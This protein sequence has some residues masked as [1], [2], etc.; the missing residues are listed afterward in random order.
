[1][2]MRRSAAPDSGG[3]RHVPDGVGRR[4]RRDATFAVE[5]IRTLAVRDDQFE[6]RP[7]PAEPFANSLGAFSGRPELI[8]I[9]FDAEV[10][11]YVASR[12]WHRSQDIRTCDDGSIVM[13]LTVC[14]DRPLRTWILGFGGAAPV[15]APASLA[16]DIYEEFD[17]GRDRYTPR[18]PFDSLPLAQDRPF[19]SLPPMRLTP[20][21]MRF[22]EPGLPFAA[23][24][25]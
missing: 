21:K 2:R 15:L 16:R 23:R 6:L 14:S 7:L 12:E 17:A 11:A 5:R 19:D 8:E 24:R 20:V 13:R 10:A 9:E 25:A 3:R 18:L 1:M 4:L 22:E